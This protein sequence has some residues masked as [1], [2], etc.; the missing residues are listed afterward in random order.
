M[1]YLLTNEQADKV[2]AELQKTYRIFAPHRFAKQGRYSD[3]DIVR[4][5]EVSRV[6]DIEF[7]QKSDFPAKEVLSPIQR[8]MF[9]FNEENYLEN[10]SRQKPVLIF[11]RPC[12]INAQ[13]IQAKIYDGNGGFTDPYYKRIHDLVKFVLMDCQGGTDSCFCVSMGTN[14]TEDYVLAVRQEANGLKVAVK[15]SSF[16][17]YFQA[18][19]ACDFTPA[20][21]EKNELTVKL[22]VIPNKTVLTKLKQH[23]MWREFD[24][25]CISCGACTVACSTCTCFTTRDIAYTE[26][27]LSGERR[28]V[29]DSC[30]VAGFDQMAGQKEI[31]SRAGDRMRYKVLH[32]F[33]DYEARFHEGPMCVGCGR[34]I[35]RCPE[36]ISIAATVE[37]MNHALEEIQKEQEATK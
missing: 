36:F 11:G 34:C 26:N 25:R 20:F 12:D 9:Y 37:K 6:E 5:V 30:Q 18:A 35:D 8:T 21:V 23:P 31:R 2:F 15:D 17:P 19:P 16:L 14:K 22:P 7:A 3:T 33:H 27:H 29:T 13:K 4:Y 1:S 10:M 24:K 32:K 28:R